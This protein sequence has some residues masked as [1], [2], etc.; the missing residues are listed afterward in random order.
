MQGKCKFCVFSASFR[1]LSEE[2]AMMI[3]W[4]VENKCLQKGGG[5]GCIEYGHL[6]C[7]VSVA[8]GHWVSNP[9]CSMRLLRIFGVGG[10]AILRL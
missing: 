8:L 9:S 4:C 1:A 6:G 10:G 2:C 3:G 5:G 7:V